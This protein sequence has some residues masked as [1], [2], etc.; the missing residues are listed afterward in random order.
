[1]QAA[2]ILV[3]N[4]Y[5]LYDAFTDELASAMTYR[6]NW[7][8]TSVRRFRSYIRRRKRDC[9]DHNGLF[10]SGLFFL[11]ILRFAPFRLTTCLTSKGNTEIMGCVVSNTTLCEMIL[12]LV[13]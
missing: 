3:S 1:M 7:G 9:E 8:R 13:L 6:R 4:F 12:R 11:T 10:G 5:T 2:R